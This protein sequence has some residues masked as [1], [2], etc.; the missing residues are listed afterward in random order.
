LSLRSSLAFLKAA[1]YDGV[2][3]FSFIGRVE[4]DI[5]LVG[6]K[7][8]EYLSQRRIKEYDPKSAADESAGEPT[9]PDRERADSAG[10]TS[11]RGKANQL[12]LRIS[13]KRSDFFLVACNWA[14]S[15]RSG[16]A[17]RGNGRAASRR[18]RC[19][20]CC[21]RMDPVSHNVIC[22]A[23]RERA[24][25][26]VPIRRKLRKQPPVVAATSRW[27]RGSIGRHAVAAG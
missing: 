2:S 24:A 13:P 14:E 7:L 17:V 15:R 16:R 27:A 23:P 6:S 26:V 22:R 19:T 3:L 18:L 11:F 20:L 9:R 21:A 5:R 25:A 8:R 4:F 1:L 12:W 10:R